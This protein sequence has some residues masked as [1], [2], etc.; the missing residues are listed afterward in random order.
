M[1]PPSPLDV[2]E[3]LDH[4]ISFLTPSA[5]D[6]I[7]CALVARSWLDPAQSHL[8]R[9]PHDRTPRYNISHSVATSLCRTLSENPPLARH[10]REFR[11][12][13]PA[14]VDTPLPDLLREIQFPNLQTLDIAYLRTTSAPLPESFA[15]LFTLKSLKQLKMYLNVPPSPS[16]MRAV[17]SC[18]A[19]IQHLDLVCSQ[20]L[21]DVS[22]AE[23]AI[24]IQLK[25]LRLEYRKQ[26]GPHTID[27][28]KFL[29]PFG[30]SKLNAL[31]VRGGDF[32]PWELIETKNIRVLEISN[33]L[34]E[35]IPSIDLSQF[36]NLSVLRIGFLQY[37]P[38]TIFETLATIAS[39]HRIHTIFVYFESHMELARFEQDDEDDFSLCEELDQVLSSVPLD[40]LPSVEVEAEADKE[41]VQSSFPRLVAKHMASTCIVLLESTEDTYYANQLRVIPFGGYKGQLSWWQNAII[42][43]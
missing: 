9:V 16:L 20:G 42:Q 19:T 25:S 30:L 38:P 8:F 21:G 36:P 37:V 5:S 33:V 34:S 15:Q 41:T 24:R 43:L 28:M 40:P 11:L 22:T 12:C 7:S 35:K 39:S 31:A 17:E 4:T 14:H 32:V 10:V 1:N 13:L 27:A 6:L 18:S 23:Q 2:H 26:Y 3:L 29:S